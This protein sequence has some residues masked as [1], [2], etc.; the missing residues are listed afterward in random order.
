M[1]W[2]PTTELAGNSQD[3]LYARLAL[4]VEVAEA[5]FMFG[6]LVLVRAMGMSG[7][8]PG[9]LEALF[10]TAYLAGVVG[11]IL[12][13]VGLIKGSARVYALLALALGLVNFAIGGVIFT[14]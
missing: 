9:W 12:A 11:L 1:L 4:T 7:R 5:V 8:A 13:V 6:G 3:R 14:V 2:A 10:G